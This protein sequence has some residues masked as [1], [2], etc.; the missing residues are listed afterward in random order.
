MFSL[1]ATNLLRSQAEPCCTPWHIDKFQ[2]SQSLTQV[3]DHRNQMIKK[4]IKHMIKFWI[5]WHRKRLHSATSLKYLIH[6]C[7]WRPLPYNQGH[8]NQSSLTATSL[9]ASLYLRTPFYFSERWVTDV[10]HS[11]YMIDVTN[12]SLVSH[13]TSFIVMDLYI[14]KVYKTAIWHPFCTRYPSII[15]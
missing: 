4:I 5:T 15:A 2:I 14:I 9:F 1:S 7:I 12:T 3:Q 11:N 10:G 13:S 8:D 6:D